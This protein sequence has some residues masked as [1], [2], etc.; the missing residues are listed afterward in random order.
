MFCVSKK[1][2]LIKQANTAARVSE[3]AT[4]QNNPRVGSCLTLSHGP[5]P[6]DGLQFR[7]TGIFY[8]FEQI[9]SVE[10]QYDPRQGGLP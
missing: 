4:R 8:D 3:L 5:A 6:V 7:H 10:A 9:L 2:S 1:A